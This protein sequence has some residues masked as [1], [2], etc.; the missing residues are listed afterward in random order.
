MDDY[1]VSR[2]VLTEFDSRFRA[3]FYDS[4]TRFVSC[5]DARFAQNRATRREVGTGDKLHE[6]GNIRFGVV[7][8]VDRRVY[9]FGD[10]VRRDVACHTDC[11]TARSVDEKFGDLRRHY[12]GFLQTAVVVVAHIDGVFVEIGHDLARDFSHSRFGVPHC[13]RAV[14][15]DRAE[16]ALTV[17]EGVTHREILRHSDKCLVN[18]LVAVRMVF[19]DNVADD[20]RRLFVSRVVGVSEFLHREEHSAVNRFQT[21][22]D[23]GQRPVGNDAHRIV[24]ERRFHGVF[25]RDIFNFAV[26]QFVHCH[27]FLR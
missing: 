5:P 20:S 10:V 8:K 18:C 21:V 9:S 24:D 11:D 3:D 22:S 7:D 12:F 4:F 23:I 27:C 26:Y 25:D 17:N 16:V 1:A 13:S 19:T 6:F 2:A 14:A 15:V